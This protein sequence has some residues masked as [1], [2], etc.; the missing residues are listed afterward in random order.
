M[1]FLRAKQRATVSGA[2]ALALY[3][4]RLSDAFCDFPLLLS[5]LFVLRFGTRLDGR[6]VQSAENEDIGGRYSSYRRRAF[7]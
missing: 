1:G 6:F 3:F 4:V 5:G 2:F 7:R